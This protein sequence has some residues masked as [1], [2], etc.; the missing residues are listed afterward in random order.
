M[1]KYKANPANFVDAKAGK[2]H[3]GRN[4]FALTKGKTQCII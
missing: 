2:I 4:F 1:K 3:E